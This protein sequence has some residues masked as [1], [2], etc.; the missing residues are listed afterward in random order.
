MKAI[1]I[2]LLSTLSATDLFALPQ[3]VI[4]TCSHKSNTEIHTFTH[5]HYQLDSYNDG[6]IVDHKIAS[7][8]DFKPL[9]TGQGMLFIS[10]SFIDKKQAEFRIIYLD[11]QA[12]RFSSDGENFQDKQLCQ[13]QFI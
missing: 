3:K 2:S 10:E 6:Q 13:V 7:V 9:I 12:Y 1:L 5:S 11:K 8:L 4:M